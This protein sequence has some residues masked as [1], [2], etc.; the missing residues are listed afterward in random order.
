MTTVRIVLVAA[1]FGGLGMLLSIIGVTAIHGIIV[2]SAAL[3]YGVAELM[4][5]RHGDAR[6]AYDDDLGAVIAD[7]IFKCIR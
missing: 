4:Q 5:E 7:P 1:S 6:A 2:L 3:F